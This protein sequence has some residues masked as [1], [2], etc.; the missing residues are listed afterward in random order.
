MDGCRDYHQLNTTTQAMDDPQSGQGYH[1]T[2]HICTLI[3]MFRITFAW[4]AHL[5]P[6]LPK[7]GIKVAKTWID[8]SDKR[9]L[10]VYDIF[11]LTDSKKSFEHQLST[12][13]I[14]ASCSQDTVFTHAA[15]ASC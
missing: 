12:R 13:L 2:K 9:E 15:C 5:A 1:N 8:F 10:A 4:V 7:R 3:L 6:L 14:H 11:R